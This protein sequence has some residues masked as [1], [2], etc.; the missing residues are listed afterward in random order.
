[1]KEFMT[2]TAKH[3]DGTPI[4]PGDQVRIVWDNGNKAFG[5]VATLGKPMRFADMN[6][7]ELQTYTVR[8]TDGRTRP[9][10]ARHIK[11]VRPRNPNRP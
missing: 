5:R 10:H 6:F 7:A 4:E 1:L 3:R 8:C 2:I 9:A 11:Y